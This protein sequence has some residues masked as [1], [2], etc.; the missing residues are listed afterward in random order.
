MSE[1]EEVKKELKITDQL[2]NE[3]Q[4]VL[5][6]I[7]ECPIHGDNCIPHYMDWIE[8]HKGVHTEDLKKMVNS[9]VN[10]IEKRF[11]TI[12]T[13]LKK[14]KNW[15][16]LHRS[17][18]QNVQQSDESVLKQM[19]G[20]FNE[21]CLKQLIRDFAEVIIKDLDDKTTAQSCDLKM[22]VR[23]PKY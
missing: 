14:R 11:S 12:E 22:I 21:G 4:M 13:D 18:T 3:R 5:N 23:K 10:N 9:H 8:K 1:L 17:V 19:I 7:P 16:A 2:L 20:Y 6:T 15:E